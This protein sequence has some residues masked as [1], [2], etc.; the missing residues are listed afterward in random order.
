MTYTVATLEI[1]SASHGWITKKLRE[2]GYDHA[3]DG[4]MLDMTHVALVPMKGFE[5][6]GRED[7]SLSDMADI[8]CESAFKAGFAAAWS[9]EAYGDLEANEE[10]AW[11]EWQDSEEMDE[12]KG[13]LIDAYSRIREEVAANLEARNQP[14]Q[15]LI[16]RA[17]ERLKVKD[18]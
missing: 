2:A 12:M 13:K 15:D 11:L 14:Y 17:A 16:Q 1:P 5:F 6:A 7:A 18:D 4:D 10:R 8:I 9:C 3:I